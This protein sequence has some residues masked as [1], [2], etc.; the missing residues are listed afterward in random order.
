MEWQ[1]SH[2]DTSDWW[3]LFYM[4]LS[5]ILYVSDTGPYIRYQ[6]QFPHIVHVQQL[7]LS[8]LLSLAVLIYSCGVTQIPITKE[9][10]L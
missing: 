2:L 4:G 6:H 8:F 3:L 9:T 1:R 10:P 7:E 5:S